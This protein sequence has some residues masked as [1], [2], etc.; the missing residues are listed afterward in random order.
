VHLDDD[1]VEDF[2]G[3][4]RIFDGKEQTLHIGGFD[5]K[6]FQRRWAAG[7]FGTLSEGVTA[8][9]G[10]VVG[11]R[12][13]LTDFRSRVHLFEI[14]TGKEVATLTLTDRARRLCPR[15]DRGTVWIQVADHENV[16]VDVAAGTASP[17]T[18]PA[19]CVGDFA[20]TT[21]AHARA[22]CEKATAH[23]PGT[24]GD[25]TLGSGPLAVT[26]GRKSPGTATAMAFAAGGKGW[27]ATIPPDPD[28]AAHVPF[29][30]PGADLAG[31]L[32]VTAYQLT[33]R[34][35][36]L[37]AF[38]AKSGER[39]WDSEIPRSDSG[40]GPAGITATEQ[41]VYVPHWTWLDIFD[42]KTGKVLGTVGKW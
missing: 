3:L 38:D 30:G 36:H 19:P 41:R 7:P 29:D 32:L 37:V 39:R 40:S 24:R 18:G 31:G 10:A 1:G 16:V 33:S 28:V 21:C 11:R 5:G 35:A 20:N 14:A 9:H 27:V 34:R 17:A 25:W 15:P 4:Y 6:T 13:L 22:A 8:T 42:L 23:A 2:V 26:I 12:A